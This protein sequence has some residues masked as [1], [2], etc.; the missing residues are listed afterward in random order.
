MSRYIECKPHAQGRYEYYETVAD[1]SECK[2]MIN[3]VCCDPE[4]EACCAFPDEEYC[5]SCSHFESETAEDI[6]ML[7]GGRVYHDGET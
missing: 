6:E 1:E 7:K 2:H 3:E 5:K 4:C